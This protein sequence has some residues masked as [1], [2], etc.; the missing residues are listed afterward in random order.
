MGFF[1][2]VKTYGDRILLSNSN[3]S[4]KKQLSQKCYINVLIHFPSQSHMKK[5]NMPKLP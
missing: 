4:K 2:L 5:L 3:N 1:F